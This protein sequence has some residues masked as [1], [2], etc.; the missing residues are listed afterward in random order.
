[1]DVHLAPILA[2]DPSPNRPASGDPELQAIV[3]HLGDELSRPLRALRE[4]FDRMLGEGPVTPDQR[5]YLRT[6]VALC[7]DLHRLI[8]GYEDFTE[9][10]LGA[11]SP[12]FGSWPVGRLIRA[13]DRQF[14][15]A[16]AARRLVWTCTLDGP[17]ATV[18]IDATCVHHVV[19]HLITNALQFTSEGGRVGVSARVE[20]PRWSVTVAD[21][22]PGI[23]LAAQARI[24]EP[25]VRL[26]RDDRAGIGG[27]GLGLA[28]C[29]ELV[30]QM[31]GE[32]AL[33]SDLGQGT[34]VTIN[35]PV[36]SPRTE[37]SKPKGKRPPAVS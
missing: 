5:G 9:L 2:A 24:F 8:R 27:H 4:G 36:G 22:G 28:I 30:D 20:G 23:P 6:M 34:R 1:M 25:F 37:P 16:S 13:W 12:R 19:G 7:D 10:V 17:D 3:S 29:R 18:S 33:V 15:S 32:I 31:N 11:V 21:D 14:A 35:L 26:P